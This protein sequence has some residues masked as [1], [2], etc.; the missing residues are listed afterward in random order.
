MEVRTVWLMFSVS[1]DTLDE[2]RKP[3][4][5]Y[6][7]MERLRVFD[8]YSPS[9]SCLVQNFRAVSSPLN[10]AITTQQLRNIG[11]PSQFDENNVKHD[12]LVASRVSYSWVNPSKI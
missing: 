3:L 1:N 6:H 5:R 9:R 12:V 11:H 4:F 8:S 7:G 2:D 10:V